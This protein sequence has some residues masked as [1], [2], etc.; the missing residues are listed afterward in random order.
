MPIGI[1]INC[2]AIIIGGALGAFMGQG[3]PT[4]IKE[5][6][7]STFGLCAIAI[8]AYLMSKTG[9]LTCVILSILIGSC[10]GELIL[11]EKR[12][13]DAVHSISK[14]L[15]LLHHS[16]E[17]RERYVTLFIMFCTGA[18][19]F[20][21]SFKEGLD[22]DSSILLTKSTLD[23]FT[24]M[25]FASTVGYSIMTLGLFQICFL[26]P[27][28]FSAELIS[29]LLTPVAINNF[30]AVGGIITLAIGLKLTGIKKIE[31]GNLLPAL[32][33]VLILTRLF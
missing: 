12:L 8:G 11:L 28:F 6:L 19:G 24:S 22:G 5:N 17:Q 14:H 32:I 26:L 18:M 4:R 7:P 31:V 13:H 30:T 2:L 33:F 27:I 3:I 16:P 10:V 15:P 9:N 29:P 1:I 25:V 21:G 23:F 20:F